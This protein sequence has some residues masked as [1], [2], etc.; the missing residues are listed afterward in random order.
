MHGKLC[1]V[2]IALY[3]CTLEIVYAQQYNDIRLDHFVQ[4]VDA[5]GNNYIIQVS[6][7]EKLYQ[8][9]QNHY[10]LFFREISPG[11]Y[12]VVD[13]DANVLNIREVNVVGKANHQWKWSADLKERKDILKYNVVVTDT[14]SFQTFVKHHTDQINMIERHEPSHAFVIQIKKDFDVDKILS[15]DEVIFVAPAAREA[16][17]E[18]P[19]EFQDNSVNR[20]NVV[21]HRYP[22]TTGKGLHASVKERSVDPADIDLKDRI[23]HSGLADPQVSLHANQMATIIAGAGNSMLHST[24]AAWQSKISSSSFSSLLPDDHEVLTEAGI[25]VQNHSYGTDIENF[26]GA[27]ARAYDATLRSYPY[28]LHVFSSGN[29]GTLTSSTGSYAGVPS[30]GTLTGN[31]KHAK[32]VL[33]V[34]AHYKDLSIDQRN[35]RGPAYDGRVKPELV[36]FGQ[37]G[38][39][40][41][42][43][44]V[45]GVALLIQ[46]AYLQQQNI[47]PSSALV[48]SI[49]IASADR[50]DLPVDFVRGY[51]R[52][53]ARKALEL[54][55]HALLMNSVIHKGESQTLKINVPAGISKLSLAAGWI[56]REAEAGATRALV[57][58][59]DVQIAHEQQRW[60]P[61]TLNHYASLDSLQQP[62]R[63]REDHLNTIEFFTIENPSPGIYDVQLKGDNLTDDEQKVEIAYWLDSAEVFQW[64]YPT[65]SDPVEAGKDMLLRWD[66]TIKGVGALEVS[67]ND[68]PFEVVNNNV[69]LENGFYSWKAPL[70]MTRAT[71]RMRADSHTVVSDTFTISPS[72]QLRIGFNCEEEVMLTWPAVKGADTY[73]VL[74]LT[75]AYLEPVLETADTF[76]L[77]KKNDLPYL[78]FA[79]TPVVHSHEGFRSLSYNYR[80][81]GVRCYY[82]T[83][84]AS[85]L[86]DDAI[87][88]LNLSTTR[89]VKQVSFKKLINGAFSTL[90]TLPV[91]SKLQYQYVEAALQGGITYY[92]A[93]IVLHDGTAIH[94]DTV[95]LLY[96]DRNTYALFPNPVMLDEELQVLTDGEEL[97]IEFYDPVGRAVKQQPILTSYF[98]FKVTGLTRGLYFY[99]VLRSGKPV[100]TG[101]ILII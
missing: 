12:V 40:D 33:V 27:E 11:Y 71:F 78:Y 68:E 6:S 88:N 52:V 1:T 94:T 70:G 99:K 86:D 21:H 58:D 44:V 97:V 30:Y 18:S 20:I 26:Y 63:R 47:L 43:A 5:P 36:A 95:S 37:E 45:S 62:P 7:P 77:V 87:I 79:V 16:R 80:T 42:A 74:A 60:L 76:A 67:L 96:G 73:R 93:D 25:S 65:A 83:L 17:E 23:I 69:P 101:R 84:T 75:T 34:G 72:L 31:M 41:A 38:T 61:W 50:D 35:S 24:G 82:T 54:T 13:P 10:I 98:K 8:L 64:T 3:L 89:N 14:L 15:R 90:T 4:R 66:T 56:D 39:S 9:K 51:G 92:T 48:K 100:A 53:N 55:N 85:V 2:A 91:E 59:V 28:V 46:D 49:L 81:Q 32:N 19:N 29:S 22:L 57:N